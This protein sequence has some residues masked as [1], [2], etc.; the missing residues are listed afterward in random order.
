MDRRA[1]TK[2]ARPEREQRGVGIANRPT[3]RRKPPCT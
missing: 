3:A 1:P 2:T